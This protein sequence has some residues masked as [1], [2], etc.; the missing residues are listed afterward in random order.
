MVLEWCVHVLVPCHL[1]ESLQNTSASG[2]QGMSFDQ[3]DGVTGEVAAT[4]VVSLNAGSW[5]H[6]SWS[7]LAWVCVCDDECDNEFVNIEIV[8]KAASCT[9]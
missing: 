6:F 5:K 2:S 1:L 3:T 8:I 7:S 4:A 9:A